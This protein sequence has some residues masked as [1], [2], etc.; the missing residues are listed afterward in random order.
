MEGRRGLLP[1][2]DEEIQAEHARQQARGPPSPWPAA[3]RMG[4][5]GLSPSREATDEL[6]DRLEGEG[7]PVTRRSTFLLV[8]AVNEDEATA[9]AE[10]LRHEV[11]E[12]ASVEVEPGGAMVWECAT[13][14]V[15]R[16]RRA[17]RADNV[18][19]VGYP[20]SDPVPRREEVDNGSCQSVLRAVPTASSSS[21]VSEVTLENRA[22][23]AFS[24][25]QAQRSLRL[26]ELHA[27]GGARAEK[28]SS[29]VTPPTWLAR[30]PAWRLSTVAGMSSMRRADCRGH[31]PAPSFA[32]AAADLRPSA[33]GSRLRTGRAMR[34]P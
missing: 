11:P 8:G 28:Q 30:R 29:R 24:A 17:R 21:R 34:P 13:Q 1:R 32:G 5:Q 10:R 7:I 23:I 15:R 19:P 2:T 27:P 16:L 22:E 4:G 26:F 9:L 14:P 3:R 18:P 20:V 25:L 31:R 6:A 33:T 12:G